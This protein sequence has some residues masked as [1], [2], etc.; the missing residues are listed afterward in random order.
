MNVYDAWDS[1][2]VSDRVKAVKDVGLEGKVG[3]KAK[4]DLTKEEVNALITGVPVKMVGLYPATNMEKKEFSKILTGSAKSNRTKIAAKLATKFINTPFIDKKPVRTKDITTRDS[5]P[6]AKCGKQINSGEKCIVRLYK[7]GRDWIHEKCSSSKPIDIK[8]VIEKIKKSKSSVIIPKL[9]KPITVQNDLHIFTYKGL[10]AKT[11]IWIGGIIKAHDRDEAKYVL[12]TSTGNDNKPVFNKVR[13]MGREEMPITDSSGQMRCKHCQFKTTDSLAYL[14]HKLTHTTMGKSGQNPMVTYK[15]TRGGTTFETTRFIDPEHMRK[16]GKVGY[17]V[18]SE[19][20]RKMIADPNQDPDEVVN[21]MRYLHQRIKLTTTTYRTLY[22]R[23][24]S[25][26]VAQGLSIQQ[27]HDIS[28]GQV[29]GV[30]QERQGVT[31]NPIKH[32]SNGWFWGSKGPYETREKAVKVAQAVYASGWEESNPI[33]ESSLYKSFHGNPPEKMVKV[34]FEPP[35]GTLVKIGD[36]SELR[37]KPTGVS[38]H[39]GTEFF[40]KSGDTGDAM[41]PT[42]LIVAT[43]EQGKNIYLVKKSKSELPV[44]TERGIIG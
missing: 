43:D 19:K 35:T 4:K 29:K 31:A 30:W 27:A 23:L 38:Q 7:D 5:H 20:I 11:K 24:R 17:A 40:H 25:K 22:H 42:N 18:T 44:F 14:E 37:Y 6:C 13:I 1:L 12:L 33:P 8:P 10:S 3:S 32:K 28:S 26:Q 15:V 34:F 39:V 2:T 21:L 16:I 9:T 41:K 36:L